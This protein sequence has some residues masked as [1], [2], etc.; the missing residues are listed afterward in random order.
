MTTAETTDAPK[1]QSEPWSERSV[2]RGTAQGL[3]W[4]LASLLFVDRGW[5]GYWGW[6]GFL[7][8]VL[9]GV[10]QMFL[11][12]V[13]WLVLLRGILR[14]AEPRGWGP[15][16]VFLLAF[17]LTGGRVL[18]E[19]IAAWAPDQALTPELIHDI[20]LMLGW[21]VAWGL[22]AGAYLGSLRKWGHGPRALSAFGVACLLAFLA[23]AALAYAGRGSANAILFAE[24]R[25][26]A[27][28]W[29]A[30]FAE[31]AA[32]IATDLTGLVG[33]WWLIDR[34]SGRLSRS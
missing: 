25:D 24:A 14:R 22:P 8:F 13:V 23:D 34:F 30:V 16:G 2:L 20:P 1:P 21:A 9:E 12:A 4:T 26:A 18:A 32:R 17:C 27:F 11:L 3:I 33:A 31:G 5:L 6:E 7:G 28:P 10:G 19:W 29:G 15:G